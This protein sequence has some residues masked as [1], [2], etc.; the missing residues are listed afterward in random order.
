MSVLASF[1]KIQV[2]QLKKSFSKLT[3]TDQIQKWFYWKIPSNKSIFLTNFQKPFPFNE[4]FGEN[5]LF[6]NFQLKSENFECDT[7]I[8]NLKYINKRK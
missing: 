1:A 2:K 8:W 3:K 7:S 5:N 4:F 6:R